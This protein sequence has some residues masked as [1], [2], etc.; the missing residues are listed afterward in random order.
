MTHTGH[1]FQLFI[2]GAS[3]SIDVELL[4]SGLIEMIDSP[5]IVDAD[6]ENFFCHTCGEFFDIDANW[7]FV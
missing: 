4:E 6:D 2:T 7:E 3:L 1:K 5:N